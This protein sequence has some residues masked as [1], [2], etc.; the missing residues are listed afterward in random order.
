[1]SIYKI[2]NVIEF[3]NKNY[4][5]LNVI[6]KE[7]IEYLLITPTNNTG[8]KWEEI[9]NPKDLKVDYN[10]LAILRHNLEHDNYEFEKDRETIT[11]LYREMLNTK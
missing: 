8:K 9:N 6:E 4:I 3:K 10:K 5:I 11:K 7:K 1:M 2:G